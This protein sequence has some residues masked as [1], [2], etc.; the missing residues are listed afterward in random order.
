MHNREPSINIKFYLLYL[1]DFFFDKYVW[2]LTI[3]HREKKTISRQY[4]LFKS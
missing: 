1:V 3:D 4:I 2:I